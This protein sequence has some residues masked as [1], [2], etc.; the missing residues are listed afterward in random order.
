MSQHGY[1]C[2]VKTQKVHKLVM[3]ESCTLCIIVVHMY[4]HL[5]IRQLSHC[6]S[7]VFAPDFTYVA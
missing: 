7:P 4:L 1:L 2:F 5:C 3:L 6:N